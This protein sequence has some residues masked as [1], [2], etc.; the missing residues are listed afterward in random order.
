ML[1]AVASPMMATPALADLLG[2]DA[3]LVLATLISSTALIPLT[4][5]HPTTHQGIR[6]PHALTKQF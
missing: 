5:P 1:Q 3:T 6:A 2:L 4:A